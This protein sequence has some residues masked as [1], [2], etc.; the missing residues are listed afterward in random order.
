VF[1]DIGISDAVLAWQSCALT[2]ALRGATHLARGIGEESG[3]LACYR[4]YRAGDGRFITLA[5]QEPK[6]WAAFCRAV[7]RID[8]IDRQWERV[9]QLALITELDELFASAPAAEWDTR[10]SE[11]QC[12][13]QRVLDGLE[14][15]AHQQ[16]R[17]RKMLVREGQDER[18]EALYPAWIDGAPPS[19]RP[20]LI[21]V[22]LDELVP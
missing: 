11:A 19:R 6:F 15:P 4:I 21:E 2:G 20:N 1:I 3:G 9:P 8:W 10:L 13:Y 17:A 5:A 16:I 7:G 18:L 14:V 12:C 22:A